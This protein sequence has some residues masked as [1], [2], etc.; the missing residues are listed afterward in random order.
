MK[1]EDI[2]NALRRKKKKNVIPVKNLLHSGSTLLNLACTGRTAGAFAKGFYY[3][4]VGDSTSGKTWLALAAFAEAAINPEFDEY[5]L[6]YDNAEDGALMDI[7]R[8]F[9][10]GVKNRLE[11]PRGTRE[12][13]IYSET[14]EDLHYHIDDAVEDG[15]PFI[16]VMDS[17]DALETE[18]DQ[19]KFLEKKNARRKGKETTGSYG[20]M[21]AKV[22]SQYIRRLVRGA[23]KTKSIIIVISQTRDNAKSNPY[24]DPKTVAGG[25]ALK[26]YAT[27]EIWTSVKGPIKKV[28]RGKPR[29]IGIFSKVRTKKNRIT[30]HD[31]DIEVPIY[32]SVGIDDIG[33]CVNY[34][35]A[36][37]HWKGS[38]AKVKAK[39]FDFDGSKEELIHKIEEEELESELRSIVGEV[40]RDIQAACSIKRK[41][42]YQ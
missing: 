40:W 28:V 36:E 10:P 35:I 4:F 24:A 5:R 16:Y 27:V 18:E 25:R 6:I 21:K 39:E 11:P 41:S 33:S 23:R 26:F 9:G 1:N 37:Q 30:G 17:M 13:P 8:Y 29:K 20:M 7:E 2:E 14:T 22:N 31:C 34:L 42:R 38:E 12:E 3:W 15:R 32:R 19:E